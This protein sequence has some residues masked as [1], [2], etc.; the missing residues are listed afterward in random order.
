M[1]D[2]VDAAMDPVERPVKDPMVDSA[3]RESQPTELAG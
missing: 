1:S 3:L 2:G